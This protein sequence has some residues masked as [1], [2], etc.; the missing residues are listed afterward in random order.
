M[1]FFSGLVQGDS[2]SSPLCDIYY[3]HLVKRHL[4]E[5]Q[6]IESGQVQTGLKLNPTGLE[7][8][9]TGLRLLSRGMD[10]FI[11]ATTNRI[12]AERLKVLIVYFGD[13]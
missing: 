2:L 4:A 11:F 5:F 1:S 7:P 3:G 12:E 6:Q 13:I 10:D 8:D 9:Q